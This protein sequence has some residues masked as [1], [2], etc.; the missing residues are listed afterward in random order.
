MRKKATVIY[1]QL[2]KNMLVQRYGKSKG[3]YCQP[4]NH[5]ITKKFPSTGYLISLLC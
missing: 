1:S 3:V 4:I 5:A 2:M